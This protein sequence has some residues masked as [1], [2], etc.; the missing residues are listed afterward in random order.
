MV[1]ELLGERGVSVTYEAIRKWC[2][3]CG[4]PYANQLR[5]RHPQLGHKWH[6][7]VFLSIAG[8]RHY[9]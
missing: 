3:K 2:R 7:E 1:E 6:M 8:E 5:R 9:L 4:L